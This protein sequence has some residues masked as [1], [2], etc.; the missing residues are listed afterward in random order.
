M[1]NYILE[2][3]KEIQEGKT[4]VSRRVKKQY[5]KLV[6]IIEHPQGQYVFDEKKANKPIRFIEQFC[7]PHKV[8]SP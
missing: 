2:Y 6:D 8:L 1:S 3:W 5:A 7:K 4:I